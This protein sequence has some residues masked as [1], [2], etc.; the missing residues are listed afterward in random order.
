MLPACQISSFKWNRLVH[1]G[2][3]ARISAHNRTTHV[4]V[5]TWRGYYLNIF[6][7][8]PAL[9]R[10]LQARLRI[11]PRRSVGAFRQSRE[12][13]CVRTCAI[14]IDRRRR[15]PRW[16]FGEFEPAASFVRAGGH[17]RGRA[18]AWGGWEASIKLCLLALWSDVVL[19]W[20]LDFNREKF[21]CTI[22]NG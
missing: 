7:P 20:A 18:W 17:G 19:L 14:R 22:F 12:I 8:E 4:R 15:S 16:F 9:P 2:S 13:V 10:H 1:V 6:G 21:L 11:Q 5:G 3:T